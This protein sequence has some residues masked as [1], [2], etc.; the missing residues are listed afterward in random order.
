SFDALT[1]TKQLSATVKNAKGAD[2]TGAAVTWESSND[3]VATVNGSGAVT[4]V[5]NGTATV[6]ASAGTISQT[7]NV[8]VAQVATKVEP[9]SGAI[10]SG[11]V[12]QALLAPLVARIRDRLDQGIKDLS[13]SFTVSPGGGTVS[14]TSGTTGSDGQVSTTWTLGT[15]AGTHT[16]TASPSGAGS[17]AL[18]T[19]T[20]NPGLAFLLS[21]VSGDNQFGYRGSRLAQ[22]LGA[23]VRDQYGNGIPNHVVVFA[24]TEGTA[25]SAIAFTDAAGVARTGWV[26]PDAID[27]VSLTASA[28]GSGGTPLTGSPLTF[29][30]I[31][32]GLR[33][34]SVSPSPLLEGQPAVLMGNGFDPTPGNNAVMVGNMAATVTNASPTQLD[35]TVP[36]TDC[37]PAHAAN[38]TVTAGGFPSTPVA[39]T[40]NPAAFVNLAAGQQII[41]RDPT[42]FCFQF[43][44]TAAQEVYLIGVQ[45]TSETV[46]DLTGISLSATAVAPAASR[47][48]GA[49]RNLGGTAVSPVD[50]A[51][52]ERWRRH[53]A[54]EAAI[55]EDDRITWQAMAPSPRRAGAGARR[56]TPPI[57]DGNVNVG[58]TVDVRVTT[59]GG[60]QNYVDART[61]VRAKGQKGIFL[62]HI[63]APAGGFDT[64]HYKV[65][66]QGFDT[67]YF[68]N[69]SSYFGN[70]EDADG[71]G[72]VVMVF[73]P[74]V[75]KRGSLG[76]TTSCDLDARS[77]SPASNEGEFFYLRVPDP[78]GQFDD[79]YSLS[80][81]L[82]DMPPTMAHELVHV[83]Q[84]RGRRAAGG[85]FPSI[86]LAEGQAVLGEEI[87]GHAVEGRMPGQDYGLAIAINLDDENS[88][89]WY[90]TG[91]VGLGLYYGWDPITDDNFDGRVAEAPHEC[92]W[93]ALKPPNPGPCVG[94]LDP[95]GA[96]W[97]L[98]RWLS[99]R[100]YANTTPAQSAF[101]QSIISNTQ[102]GYVLLQSLVGVSID[103][104]LT[105]FAAMLQ[106]DGL[107]SAA[108][109]EL[110][111]AS[112]NLYSVFYE[113]EDGVRLRPALRLQP[114]QLT[115][116]TF[117]RTANVRA[118]STYYAVVSG[119]NREAT[120]VKA[121]DGAGGVL[122]P[123]M[124]YWI[125]RIE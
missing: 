83:I 114:A 87:M 55:R 18:F 48:F 60:C 35:I 25:D 34:T 116:S 85:P 12:G 89:D 124:R 24:T 102:N 92:S 63:T 42:Q 86:W 125:V 80:N 70:P 61:V 15:T 45:S 112:W 75:N 96:P 67:H 104:L 113:T 76:F 56:A 26:L 57:V 93:L 95:Y 31:A 29:D 122:P 16:V 90:S 37:Q 47:P 40:V 28:Q 108:A 46:T 115:Y 20:A 6:T 49:A 7:V 99:D 43:P 109:P 38:V 68:P 84:F 79:A 106:V 78:N 36:A 111:M 5:A 32:H 97:A 52:L 118:A 58:D 110:T 88:T 51:R 81:G 74:E 11:G 72:R 53:R 41:V 4:A 120:A 39:A 59:G 10:Q 9:A 91:F 103:T 117:A 65:F 123:W 69:D 44:K 54:V 94:G 66:S 73:T 82:D 62:Q 100:F 98:L 121:R 27:T 21:K 2:L 50:A 33:V 23:R 105:Q 19:A 13:V 77:T 8:T 71:N 119:F 64:T 1:D 14:P 17:S 101:H 107:V 22:L 3:P 30:A